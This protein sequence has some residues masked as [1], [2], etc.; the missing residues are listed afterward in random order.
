[1]VSV[2][3]LVAQLK[4]HEDWRAMVP[5][6]TGQAPSPRFAIAVKLYLAARQL[7]EHVGLMS[8]LTTR[9]MGNLVPTSAKVLSLL[10]YSAPGPG[11]CDE[12]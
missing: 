11:N 5:E 2:G 8:T 6:P 3:W 4:G 12:L 1:M 7:P 10:M 9:Q